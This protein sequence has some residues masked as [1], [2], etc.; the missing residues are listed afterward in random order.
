MSGQSRYENQEWIVYRLLDAIKLA[1]KDNL[2][3]V[4]KVVATDIIE[5]YGGTTEYLDEAITKALAVE[6]LDKETD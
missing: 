5:G 1:R 4:L 6:S 3:I 2:A